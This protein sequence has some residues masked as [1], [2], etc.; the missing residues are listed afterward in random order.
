MSEDEHQSKGTRSLQQ[1]RLFAHW[2]FSKETG[3]LFIKFSLILTKCNFTF[4]NLILYVL[5]EKKKGRTMTNE[6]QLKRKKDGYGTLVE[7]TNVRSL[8]SELLN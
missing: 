3:N 6:K 7:R 8:A 2:E 1:W 5:Q 4:D